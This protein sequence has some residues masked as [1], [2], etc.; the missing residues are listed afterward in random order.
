MQFGFECLIVRVGLHAL[1]DAGICVVYQC[2]TTRGEFGDRA[3]CVGEG[4]VSAIYAGR[5]EGMVF[6]NSIVRALLSACSQIAVGQMVAGQTL[7]SRDSRA[8][9]NC[10]R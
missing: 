7:A 9:E 10:Q 5:G 1:A 4:G 6:A 8:F 2:S 3:Q